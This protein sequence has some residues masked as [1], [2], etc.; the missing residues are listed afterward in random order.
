MVQYKEIRVRIATRRDKAREATIQE[1]M[2]VANDTKNV[3]R[4]IVTV[5]DVLRAYERGDEVSLHVC[6]MLPVVLIVV[7]SRGCTCGGWHA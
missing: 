3:F 4:G 1:V 7:L 2:T 6:S 5:E